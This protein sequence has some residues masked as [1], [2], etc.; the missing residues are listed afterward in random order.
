M[1][2][3]A[4]RLKKQVLTAFVAMMV[5]SAF[6]PLQ[7]IASQ[8][9]VPVQHSLPDS[10]LQRLY[11]FFGHFMHSFS[12]IPTL[13]DYDV[14]SQDSAY[15][16][17]DFVLSNSVF[18]HGRL[19]ELGLP[20]YGFVEYI[21]GSP[22]ENW[23][24]SVRFEFVSA[25]HVDSILQRYF[26]ITNFI[27]NSERVTP[28]FGFQY[29][30]GR[31]YYEALAQGSW[32]PAIPNIF[33]FYDNGNGT[34]SVRI[35]Y[36]TVEMG[37]IDENE[38]HVQFNIAVI[39]PFGDTF[40][41]LYWRNDVSQNAPIPTR[42]PSTATVETPTSNNSIN[43]TVNGSP[44]NFA[45]QQPINVDGRVLVPV[46]G[47]FETL[48]FDVDWNPGTRQAELSRA[49]DIII[50]TVGNAVFTTN[51]I[52]HTLDV[53]AQIIGGSTMLPIRAVL[54]SVG[55]ELEWDGETNTVVITTH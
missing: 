55:Y 52:S 34:Y 27:H 18:L 5:V 3:L 4:N 44:V 31:Y 12:V 11:S 7:V 19:G 26:N 54:E 13:G 23:S 8:E 48:D 32:S 45:G 29:I 2:K 6:A 22:I 49:N 40:Q 37:D 47:V 25:S 15:A 35:Q 46:R 21:G 53:P 41:M 38:V 16:A 20:H 9:R 30:N 39:Q 51:G 10:E 17:L 33:A 43:V 42:Q 50:I 1:K 14:N 24:S 28:V 36:L